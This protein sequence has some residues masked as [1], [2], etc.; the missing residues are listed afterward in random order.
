MTL[1]KRARAVARHAVLDGLSAR[2]RWTHQLDVGLARPRVA[3]PYLHAVPREEEGDLRRFVAALARDHEF[4]GY[5][6]AVRRVRDGDIDRPYVSFSFDD[7][8]ASNVRAARIL[9]EF[10]A[11]GMFFVPTGFVGTKTLA[12]ARSFFGF[13]EGCDEPAMTWD[14]LERLKERGHEIGNHTHT[15]RILASLSAQER[16]D[17]V[18]RAAEILHSRLGASDHFAWP[19]G[20]FFHFSDDAARAVFDTDHAS[21]A[22]AERGA[23]VVPPPGGER[24]LCVRRD[25]IMTEWPLRHCTYFLARSGRVASSVSNQWPENW[26]VE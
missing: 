20:R 24:A 14:D 7:G 18:G 26:H 8:F 11:P 21:C 3:L 17:E 6:E 10:G 9:E 19:Y 23:H 16:A 22:S 25:H 12:E 1:K 13:I 5:S 2:D 15:H 4:I